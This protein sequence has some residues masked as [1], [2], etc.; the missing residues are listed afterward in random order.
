MPG[1]LDPLDNT[2]P[3]SSDLVRQLAEI[4]RAMKGQLVTHNEDI[5]GINTSLEA[6]DT[7][8]DDLAAAIAAGTRHVLLTSTAQAT[9]TVPPGVNKLT[10]I[11][12][13][14]G[15][16]GWGGHGLIRNSQTRS[17]RQHKK[18]SNVGQN[19]ESILQELEVEPEEVITYQ[20][21][22]GGAAGAAATST[23]ISPGL[24]GYNWDSVE[25]RMAATFGGPNANAHWLI[26]VTLTDH[27]CYGSPYALTSGAFGQPGGTGGAT[28]F[29]IPAN[30]EDDTLVTAAGG[31]F[32]SEQTDP[33]FTRIPTALGN[34]G[35]GGLGGVNRTIGGNPP[36]DGEVGN[37]GA[38]LV[39]Y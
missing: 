34:Y 26:T 5:A 19:G 37:P 2:R 3:S 29:G 18:F 30:P 21:G 17:N 6:I 1:P 32:D 7:A 12:I 39:M 8:I 16:G 33:L 15:Q 4:L 36:E 38:I 11:A 9:W 14:G 31:T 10:V 23:Y 28:R 25:R 35:T 13:G 24:T 22:A 27:R 20:C